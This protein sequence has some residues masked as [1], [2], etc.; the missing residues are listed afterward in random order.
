MGQVVR[1]LSPAQILA[2]GVAIRDA[3]PLASWSADERFW[4]SGT[5]GTKFSDREN[6]A[7]RSLWTH[8]LA[9][10][11]YAVIHDDVEEWASRRTSMGRIDRLVSS[12]RDLV[13]G[14]A[15]TVLERTLGGDVWLSVIGIW[16]ALC[17]ALLEDRLDP[18]LRRD[19]ESTWSTVMGHRPEV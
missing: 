18:A 16:N 2:F 17:A 4:F 10:L 13:E 19:L 9:G 11:S 7:T 6:T 1:E 3:P 8:M 12:K 5:G 14:R 15:T